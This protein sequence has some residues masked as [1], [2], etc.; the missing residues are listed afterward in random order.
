[1]WPSNRKYLYLR[2]YN[3]YQYYN[4]DGKPEVFDQGVRLQS[5]KHTL[6][7]RPVLP[8]TIESLGYIFVADS[9]SLS[10]FK[11]S[12]FRG[13]IRETHVLKQSE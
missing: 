12:N 6:N 10:S 3:M 8:E 9:M 4:P 13:G 1:M 2:Q 5:S 7:L 11:I